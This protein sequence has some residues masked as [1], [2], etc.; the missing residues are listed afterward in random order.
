MSCKNCDEEPIQGAYYRWGN[1][2]VEIVACQNHWSQIRNALNNAQQS[3]EAGS[4][5]K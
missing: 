3:K 2:N 1:A 5:N 4:N